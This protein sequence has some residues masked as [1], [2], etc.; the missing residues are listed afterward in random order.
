[1]ALSVH[2]M[3]LCIDGC[4]PSNEMCCQLKPKK[5]NVRICYSELST[6]E[7]L[8]S[9]N[10]NKEHFLMYITNKMKCYSLK[11]KGM[12]QLQLQPEITLYH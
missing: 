4:G 5:T 8:Q 9:S 1:M 7:S 11:K 12:L 10:N 6:N 2:A 3:Y